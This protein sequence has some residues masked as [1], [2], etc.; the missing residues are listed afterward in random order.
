M[1]FSSML[2][3]NWWWYHDNRTR[4]LFSCTRREG[5]DQRWP[6]RSR[7][8]K[9]RM[10]GTFSSVTKSSNSANDTKTA[11]IKAPRKH[12]GMSNVRWR[13]SKLPWSLLFVKTSAQ[14]HCVSRIGTL[15]LRASC[16]MRASYS[17]SVEACVERSCAATPERSSAP[18]I[19]DAQLVVGAREEAT[20]VA[21]RTTFLAMR[22]DNILAR[23]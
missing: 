11:A 21:L 14:E 12:T 17:S 6:C 9:P 5:E 22:E 1:A 7:W 18:L 19:P 3:Q 2:G 23:L 15:P 20:S 13:A 10:C 4:L 16:C 8:A